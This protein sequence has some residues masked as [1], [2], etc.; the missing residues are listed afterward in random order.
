MFFIRS[1]QRLKLI[2]LETGIVS[3]SP[4]HSILPYRVVFS[5]YRHAFIELLILVVSNKRRAHADSLLVASGIGQTDGT[6]PIIE[7]FAH[8]LSA[9]KPGIAH[10]EVESVG[11]RL[12]EVLVVDDIEI[13]AQ[14]DFFQ[15]MGASAILTGNGTE[16]VGS[17]AGSLH[18]CRQGILGTMGGTRR[19]GIEDSGGIYQAKGQGRITLVKRGIMAME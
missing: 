15:S 7:K 6:H 4:S 12:V 10:C 9:V 17:V 5:K 2:K 13:V 1:Y 18:H 3:L 8:K 16:I 11:N 14:K 19:E